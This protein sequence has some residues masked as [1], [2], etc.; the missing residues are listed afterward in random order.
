MADF[1]EIIQEINTNLPDNNTQSITAEKL[2]TTL[3]DLTNQIDTVQDGFEA[4]VNE[5]IANVDPSFATNQNI[6]DVSIVN[7]FSGGVNNVASAETVK[8]L[9]RSMYYIANNFELGTLSSLNGNPA[10]STT[11]IRTP[12]IYV[13][14][15][16]GTYNIYIDVPQ[17]IN[18]KKVSVGYN[19][20]TYAAD[21]NTS[22]S[23]DAS[24]GIITITKDG[25]F[26]TVR[27][28]IGKSNNDTI[29]DEEVNQSY[30][31][32]PISERINEL[33]D[34]ITQEDIVN[35]FSGGSDKVASAETVKNL[36]TN[37]TE[38][39]NLVGKSVL[40][41]KLDGN[42]NDINFIDENNNILATIS[43]NGI[44]TK[45]FDSTLISPSYAGNITLSNTD[46]ITVI[47][48]SFGETEQFPT[49]KHWS[50]IMSMFSDYRIQNLS[51]SGSN[52]V[53][54]LYFI[55]SGYWNVQGK[56]VI[57]TNN[58]NIPTL[59]ITE[60][61]NGLD[62]LCTT[63]IG[64]GKIPIVCTNY[65]KSQ[66]MSMAVGKYAYEHNLM[67]WD[68]S[69]YCSS[70]T[71][72]IYGGFDSGAHLRKRNAPMVAY[73]Y[74]NHLLKMGKPFTSI[75]V[76]DI[77]DSSFSGSLDD[78]VFSNNT[79]RSKLFKEIKISSNQS[80][81][82]YNKLI[83]NTAVSFGKYGLVEVIIP[84]VSKYA[85][86]LKLNL[87]TNGTGVKVYI[88]NTNVEPY[89]NT[90]N[91][92]SIRF[93]VSDTINVPSIGDVYS[94]GGVNYT[95]QSV[96]M[97]ENNYYCTIY[98]SPSTMPSS[99]TGTLS[100]V[101]QV[102]GS[103]GSN[104]ISFV[105]A[106]EVVLDLNAFIVADNKGHWVE[107][108]GTDNSFEVPS[109][110]FNGSIQIDKL[111]FLIEATSSSFQLKDVNFDYRVSEL[112][113]VEPNKEFVWYEND[114]LHTTELLPETTFG[115]V[116]TTTSYWKDGNGDGI[117]S[118]ADYEQKYPAGATSMIK[119]SDTLSMNISVSS[120]TLDKLGDM[121]LEIYCRYFPSAPTPY[122]EANDTNVNNS[123]FDFNTLYIK[124]SAYS[125]FTGANTAIL[126]DE[127]GLYWKIVRIP[128]CWFI[129]SMTS[130]TNLYLS[131]YSNS[132]GIEVC[133]VSL[134]YND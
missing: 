74:L 85:E 51:K 122:S 69:K 131:L 116:G 107:L 34:A 75:K 58:E 53:S 110:L 90:S 108:S 21:I 104:S 72:G 91:S 1:S 52:V 45:N 33:N 6:N 29:T 79:E 66:L 86:Y 60:Y 24:N 12:Y 119:V 103:I 26:D 95:V 92:S 118:I 36:N 19:G 68:C 124:C 117:V 32:R 10:N 105:M 129:N 49:N 123:S 127:I 89:P 106:E 113:D 55:R 11:R 59:D 20:T 99:Q 15:G 5:A 57:I 17:N 62:N 7:D 38:I 94:N 35:D 73:A 14:D 81:D 70:L 2:R 130:V 30:I 63:L 46:V 44:K 37:I 4:E 100:V 65:H 120:S 39:N 77:R 61:I 23:Y 114:F 133:K 115:T 16:T 84:S 80:K 112:K 27:I 97:G 47:G 132:N 67:F 22:V 109:N 43:E 88:K 25:T 54:N 3:I 56:Y 87:N 64:M 126:T 18:T 40:S 93:S 76:F 111:S 96:V 48:S 121:Y 31:Q 41:A 101:S 102:S 125:S 82:E 9:N 83:S 50:G 8:T 71:S 42:L 134:K 13:G 28:A 128:I 78:L 98:C